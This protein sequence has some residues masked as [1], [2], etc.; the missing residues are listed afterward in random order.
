MRFHSNRDRPQH[1]GPFALERLARAADAPD[2]SGTMPPEVNA[3]ASDA[4]IID[5]AREYSGLFATLLEG[6]IAP[7]RAPIP[8][9]PVKRAENLKAAA[10]FLDASVVGCCEIKP[11]DWLGAMPQ[12]YTHALVFLIEFGREPEPGEPGDLWI[13][14]T[15]IART[16][17]R[18][19][20]L[21]AILAGYVRSMGYSA[22]GHFADT[23][24]LDLARLAVRAGVVRIDADGALAAPF[25]RRGFRISEQLNG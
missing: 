23:G 5:S 13:R 19:A 25:L 1:L 24:A 14:G 9:D 2:S 11:D 7:A 12:Q 18:C 8:A 22:S 21:A 15:N 16:D 3:A 6:P 10:Y 20:E 4:S 17:V